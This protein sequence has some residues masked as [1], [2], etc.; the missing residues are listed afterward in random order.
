MSLVDYLDSKKHLLGL[1]EVYDNQPYRSDDMVV[2]CASVYQVGDMERTPKSTP[3]V[4]VSAATGTDQ[5]TETREVAECES[6]LMIDI[7][8][9]YKAKRSEIYDKLMEFFQFGEDDSSMVL[10]MPK[11]YNSLASYEVIR[12][13]YPDG[14]DDEWRVNITL[15]CNF[16]EIRTR[17]VSV[18]KAIEL[19]TTI[20]HNIDDESLQENLEI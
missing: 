16:A 3:R 9:G 15:N 12:V 8:A 14:P 1:N 6:T 20:G 18:I 11:Y 7:Y 10:E 4:I 2:P 13:S 17:I 19:K 5:V